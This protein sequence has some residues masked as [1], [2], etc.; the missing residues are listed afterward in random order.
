M[1][2]QNHVALLAH[3]ERD[4]ND[5]TQYGDGSPSSFV[6][7]A[8]EVFKRSAKPNGAASANVEKSTATRR[9]ADTRGLDQF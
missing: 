4:E 5:P 2:P 3:M 8:A 6:A 9:D 7:K 1:E